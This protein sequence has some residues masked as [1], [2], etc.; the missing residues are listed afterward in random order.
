MQIINEINKAYVECGEEM[1]IISRP[2]VPF[3]PENVTV[4]LGKPDEPAE[5]VTVSFPAY[6]KNVA[7]SEIYPTWPESAIRANIY[8]QITFALN[9]IFT[10]RY[11]NLGYDFDIT[12][13]TQFDQSFVPGRDI[14]ENISEVVDEIFNSYIVRQGKIEPIAASYCDGVNVDCDGLLQWETVTLAEDGY[15]PY[16]ILKYYYGEDIDLVTDVPVNANF[17]SYPLY[18]LRLGSFGRDVFIIQ[19]ELNRIRE[20]YPAIPKIENPDGIFRKDTEDAVKAFQKAFDLTQDG[21]IGSATWYKI[22]YIYNA[23][24]GLG[25][26]IS[27]GIEP[28]EIESPFVISWQEGDS[29]IWVRLIQYYVRAIACY[30]GDIPMI[31]LTSYFGPET[32]EAVKALQTKFDI[33][34]DGVVGIQT[35]A[36]LDKIYRKIYSEISEGCF[37]NKTIYP[38]YLLSKGMGD[39]NVTLMQT[40]LEKIYQYYPFIPKVSVTG[41]FDEQT[42]A[43]ARAIQREYLGIDTGLIGPATWSKIAELYENLEV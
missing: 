2:D 28:E 25:E 37:K 1:V 3:I 17:E 27:E 9:R 43:A 5:N 13:S 22:K 40:Y 26:L 11:R 23:V 39:K 14:F 20:N 24:K 41:I 31:E 36:V 15:S 8:A 16:D 35:W 18:P 34:I 6:I 12:N 38:G 4:H 19:Q 7:S 10:E 32:T 33:I 21:V 29:G 30:Y 42:E